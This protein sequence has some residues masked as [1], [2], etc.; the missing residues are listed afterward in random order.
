MYL[1]DILEQSRSLWSHINRIILWQEC[2]KTGFHILTRFVYTKARGIN[3]AT[4]QW[5]LGLT[6]FRVDCSRLR[7]NW[8][9]GV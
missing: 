2:H 3:L 6:P 5:G 1:K 8:L 9:C 4:Q 7:L